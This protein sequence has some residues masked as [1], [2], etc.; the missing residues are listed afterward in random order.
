VIY[1]LFISDVIFFIFLYQRYIYKIDPKRVNEFGTSQEMFEEN[2]DNTQSVQGEEGNRAI[3]D[4]DKTLDTVEEKA[5]TSDTVE[6]NAKSSETVEEKAKTS[7]TV[8]E[9][10]APPKSKKE[11][12][13]D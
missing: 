9:K 5:K 10:A 12:K 8:E 4:S 1:P 11:K 7:D 13:N 6:E 2:G 3:E